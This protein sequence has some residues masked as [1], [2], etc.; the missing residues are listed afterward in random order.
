MPSRESQRLNQPVV[1]RKPRKARLF[2]PTTTA[3]F[4]GPAA[5]CCPDATRWHGRCFREATPPQGSVEPTAGQAIAPI[6]C[7][8]DVSVY[9]LALSVPDG[10]VCVKRTFGCRLENFHDFQRKKML[11][12]EMTEYNSN[13]SLLKKCFV[14]E[15]GTR[16]PT[17]DYSICLFC[18]MNPGVVGR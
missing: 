7:R 17:G 6:A 2:E 15:H 14:S 11:L 10:E 5:R 1:R 16:R 4:V 9:P 18:L 13:S 12:R 8:A 3:A